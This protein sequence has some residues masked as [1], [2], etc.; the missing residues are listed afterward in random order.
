[1]S[2]LLSIVIVTRN[3]KDL[4]DALL[5]SIEADRSLR[6]S[7]KEVI[8]VDNGSQDGTET[9]IK[10][11]YPWVSF[12]RNSVNRGF[13][14]AVNQGYKASTA[15]FVLFL[16]SDTRLIAGEMTRLLSFMEQQSDVGIAAPQLVYEDMVEQRSFAPAPSLLL[17]IVPKPV[18]E[19]IFP[20][21]FGTKGKNISSPV[22][23]ESV[24]GAALVTR[25]QTLDAV[26]GFDERFFF[27]ME[28]TDFCLRARREGFRV[29]FFPGA[30]LIHLQGKTVKQTWI[31]GR[32][33]YSI[34][35]Y[36]FIRKHHSARYYAFFV[37]VR[38]S[39]A[40]F[41]L[42][43]ATLLPVVLLKESIRRRYLYYVHLLLWHL[44]RC[45]EDGGLRFSSRGQTELRG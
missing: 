2:H 17:E 27:F 45:P 29:I 38:I 4:L 30:K 22:D 25:R 37:V 26:G 34:S 40:L 32:I 13:A 9:M 16:N 41:F 44:R 15:D 10:A 18:L 21:R 14:A 23:V 31:R 12:V 5:A 3:T 8:V 7:T 42:L 33:E 6:E 24:I 19:V 39:K 11:R 36:K 28:E 43:P 35:L 1:M 20:V